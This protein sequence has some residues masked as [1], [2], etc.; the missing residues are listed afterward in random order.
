MV[1]VVDNNKSQDKVISKAKRMTG[2]R[3]IVRRKGTGK[4]V[5]INRCTSNDL[6]VTTHPVIVMFDNLSLELCRLE[7]VSVLN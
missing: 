2:K 5:G 1:S 6:T 4:V 7:D 3:C